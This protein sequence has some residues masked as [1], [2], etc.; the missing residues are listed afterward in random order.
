VSTGIVD[1]PAPRIIERTDPLAFSGDEQ[2]LLHLLGPPLIATPRA[3]KR[4]ANSYGL[5]SALHSADLASRQDGDQPG[6]R[7]AMVL[8]ATLVGY[9]ELGPGLFP[10]IHRRAAA[11]PAAAWSSLVRGLQPQPDGDTWRNEI[12]DS[13]DQVRAQQW[14]SLTRALCRIEEQAGN[15]DLP[16][17]GTLATWGRWIQPVGRLSFPTGRVVSALD[18]HPPLPTAPHGTGNR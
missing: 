14:E 6:Y 10:H 18:R 13:L 4:L 3:A 9:P 12:H 5:L 8:L 15:Q 1:L 17:P 7:A 2:R 16:L 11:D